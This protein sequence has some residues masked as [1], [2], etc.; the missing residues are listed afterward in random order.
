MTCTASHINQLLDNTK[1]PTVKTM[2]F[3]TGIEMYI[4]FNDLT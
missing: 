3:I 1:K 2:T 4:T